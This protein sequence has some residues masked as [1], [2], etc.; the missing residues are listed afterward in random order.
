MKRISD[1]GE[2]AWESGHRVPVQMI[3]VECVPGNAPELGDDSANEMRGDVL[4]TLCSLLVY[5]SV[6]PRPAVLLDALA[7]VT[8]LILTDAQTAKVALARKHGLSFEEFGSIILD[9]SQR[10]NLNAV[11]STQS[12]IGQTKPPGRAQVTGCSNVPT[13]PTKHPISHP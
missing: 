10:L 11:C 13:K 4:E 8:G 3:P 5:L 7:V 12:G 2:M 9:V 6:S 1:S